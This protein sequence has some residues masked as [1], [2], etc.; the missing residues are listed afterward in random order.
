MMESR[1]H[2]LAL[3]DSG[4]LQGF[5]WPLHDLTQNVRQIINFLAM[6]LHLSPG[7]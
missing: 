6:Q 3:I 7:T 1:R 4:K 5:G 2:V